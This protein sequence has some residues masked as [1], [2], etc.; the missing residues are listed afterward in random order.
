M[1]GI[2][3]ALLPLLVCVARAIQIRPSSPLL[4]HIPRG[5]NSTSD[6]PGLVQ[7]VYIASAQDYKC[8]SPTN[9]TIN[10]STLSPNRTDPNDLVAGAYVQSLQTNKRQTNESTPGNDTV[11]SVGAIVSG[12]DCRSALS[13]DLYYNQAGVITLSGT[14]LVLDAND[15]DNGVIFVSLPRNCLKFGNSI[16]TLR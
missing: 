14:D 7:N 11:I 1:T 13:W 4:E 6:T 15:T 8:L 16:L 2:S 12:V 9:T 5:V 10:I 3:F